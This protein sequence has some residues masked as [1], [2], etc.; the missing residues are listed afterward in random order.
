MVEQ[1]H[2]VVLHRHTAHYE[3]CLNCEF[4]RARDPYWLEEAYSSAI[5]SADTGLVAR[6]FSLALKVSAVL[7]FVLD[8]RG[9]GRYLDTAG[10]YGMFTRL[11][12][13]FGYDYYWSD[14]YCENLLAKGFEFEADSGPCRAVTAIE[15]MEHLIDP[16]EFVDEAMKKAD[17]GTLLFTT[18]LYAGKPPAQDWWYYTFATG[19]HICFFSQKTLRVMGSRLG[20]NFMTAHGLHAFSREPLRVARYQWATHPHI[21]KALYL[22]SRCVLKSR[23]FDDHLNLLAEVK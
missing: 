1:F 13:D 18:E 22:Y 7:F 19:Q 6:N 16:L 10:G 2:A 12:R 21:S 8:E 5:A 3:H 20:L 15:V 17:A 9:P 4:L 11:M 23:T 14:R